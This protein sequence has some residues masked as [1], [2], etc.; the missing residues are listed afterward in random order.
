MGKRR[1]APTASDIDRGITTARIAPTGPVKTA[2]SG[3][4]NQIAWAEQ[5]RERVGKEFDRIGSAL[6]S[7]ATKQTELDRTDTQAIVAILEERRLEVMAN[8]RAGY[9][10]HDWQELGDQ[11]RQMVVRDPLYENIKASRAARKSTPKI[12]S[13]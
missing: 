3:V 7:V 9:F 1:R 2:L 12:D 6:K 10:I 13:F 4:A 11:V 5:I 8:N